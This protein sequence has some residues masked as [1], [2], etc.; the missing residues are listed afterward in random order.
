MKLVTPLIML[1]KMPTQLTAERD[2]PV[3][4][5]E[6]NCH[7]LG[8]MSRDYEWPLEAKSIPQQ[9]EQENEDLGPQPERT[10]FCQQQHESGR[11]PQVLERK[12]Y[13]TDIL[14]LTL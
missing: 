4:F 12:D 2:F 8:H 13:P 1:Y 9:T 5:V 3:G 6:V 7:V 14:I 11:C 10:E